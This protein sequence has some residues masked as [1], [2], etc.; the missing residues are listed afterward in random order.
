MR[1]FV[2]ILISL[3][4]MFNQGCGKPTVPM[5]SED[6][7][8]IN[9]VVVVTDFPDYPAYEVI[10]TTMFNNELSTVEDKSFKELLVNTT[11]ELLR[12]KGYEVE[13]RG[14][15][16]KSQT[17]LIITV[18][19]GYN[20]FEKPPNDFKNGYGFF[21]HSSFGNS[22]TRFSYVA[23]YIVPTYKGEVRCKSCGYTEFETAHIPFDLPNVWSELSK[24]EEEKISEKLNNNIVAAVKRGI[25]QTGL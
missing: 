15:D 25:A 18:L 2:I 10:G 17:D 16:Y 24:G 20:F 14:L 7:K 6:L 23:L 21:E 11:I 12:T 1:T 4:T 13:E 5:S 9:K 8:A 22:S 19:S 3:V